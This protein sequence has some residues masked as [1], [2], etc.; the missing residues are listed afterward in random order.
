MILKNSVVVVVV[1]IEK[2]SVVLV[3]VCRIRN[4]PIIRYVY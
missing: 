4:I 1:D 3:I 2:K